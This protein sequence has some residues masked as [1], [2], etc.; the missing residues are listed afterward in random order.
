VGPGAAIGHHRQSLLEGLAPLALALVLT[1]ST[2]LASRRALRLAAAGAIVVVSS[3]LGGAALAATKLRPPVITEHFTRLACDENTTIGME[4][5]AERQLLGLDRRV[6]EEVALVF[7]ELPTKA[8]KLDFIAAETSW[9]SYRAK[10]CQSFA[11]VY[12]NGTFAP[13]EY[14][15]CEAQDDRS[16]STDLKALFDQLHLGSENTPAWP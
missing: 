9:F 2:P 6:N 8:Q 5:C 14:A 13:V 1:T 15:Q 7:S 4:G 11:A 3:L 10:D 12:T 16:R